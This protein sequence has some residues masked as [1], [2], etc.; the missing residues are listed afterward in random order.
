MTPS[1]SIPITNA[2][3]PRWPFDLSVEAKQTIH[4]AR[5]AFVMNIFEPLTTYS[6][7]RRTAVVWMPETSEPAPGSESPKQPRIG[8]ETSGASHS[9]FC[10]SVPAIRIG[11]A[12]RPFAP[13]EVPMPEQPQLSSSP[14]SIP[15]NADSSG[16]P[17]DS[18]TWRFI[19]PSSCALA[20][21]SA[22][23]VWCSS[24]SAAFGRI[25]FS[26][27][28]RASARSSLCSSVNANDTPFASPVSIVAMNVLL[29]VD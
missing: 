9:R 27:N 12:A 16:P 24:Y 15:S 26:A 5:P 19:S 10:S 11:P 3:R 14:T 22:G 28:S 4:D 1:A 13:I 7:P 17:S 8:S 18:G 21:T 25:S 20:T 2:V 29:N 23:C 6:P